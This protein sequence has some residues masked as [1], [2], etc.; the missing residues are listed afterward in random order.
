MHIQI[1]HLNVNGCKR[2]KEDTHKF[3]MRCLSEVFKT[4]IL[5]LNPFIKTEHFYVPY[6]SDDAV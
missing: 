5:I 2:T 3:R 1:Q 4:T 6:G